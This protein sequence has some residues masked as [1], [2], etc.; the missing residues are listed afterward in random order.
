MNKLIKVI[1][2]GCLIVSPASMA[3]ASITSDYHH[4]IHNMPML[5]RHDVLNKYS[6]MVRDQYDYQTIH[7][8]IDKCQNAD[9]QSQ[10]ASHYEREIEYLKDQIKHLRENERFLMERNA[11]LMRR[12]IK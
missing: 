10:Q 12:L 4:I 7:K 9:L 8:M 3:R 5:G 6:E 2:L 1:I 11:E